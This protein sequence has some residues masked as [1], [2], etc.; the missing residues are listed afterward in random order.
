MAEISMNE[1]V[2]L[3]CRVDRSIVY[4]GQIVEL[5]PSMKIYIP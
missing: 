2:L 3:V 1:F 5:M 4:I